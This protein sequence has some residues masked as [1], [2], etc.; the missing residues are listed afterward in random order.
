[1]KKLVVFF[2]TCVILLSACLMGCQNDTDKIDN[3]LQNTDDEVTTSPD[4]GQEL[5]KN[6]ILD[7]PDDLDYNNSE[8]VIL[9]YNSNVKEFGDQTATDVISQTQVERDAMVED[10]L[11][12]LISVESMNGQWADRLTYADTVRQ[13]VMTG[14]KKWDLIGAYSYVAPNLSLNEVIVD[15]RTTEYLDF[16][17]VWWPQ[18]MVDITTV[19]DKTFFISGDVSVNTLYEMIPIFFNAEVLEAHGF[20]ETALYNMV[21]EGTWTIENFFGMIENASVLSGDTVWNDDDLYAF[22]VLDNT[23]FDAFYYTELAAFREDADGK[24]TVAED[25]FLGEQALDIFE[26]VYDAV[27]TFHSLYFN[28]TVNRLETKQTIFATYKLYNMRV[29][30]NPNQFGIL[31]WPKYEEG[32]NTWYQTLLGSPHTQYCI[33]MDIDD[34]DR[35]SAVLEMLA[36]TSYTYLTPVVFEDTMQLRYSR[37]ENASEMFD[38]IRDGLTTDLGI[39]YYDA[40]A[41]NVGTRDVQSIFRN[42]ILNNKDNWVS[43]YNNNYTAGLTKVVKLLNDLYE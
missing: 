36:Y 35:S 14:N 41:V 10:A 19:N 33:P 15:M 17:K 1:M 8:F 6:E 39:L 13:N 25:D 18:Y 27:N 24:L 3:T 16:S 43:N 31:P 22:T 28:T 40:F 12:I 7:I 23:C 9:T 4:A 30:E 2:M 26:T 5:P 32:T 21:R 38:I 34:V 20:S 37:D 42:L 29:T 11:G